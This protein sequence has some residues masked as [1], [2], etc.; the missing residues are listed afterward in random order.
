MY[1]EIV[2]LVIEIKKKVENRLGEGWRSEGRKEK[3]SLQ[4][5]VVKRSKERVSGGLNGGRGIGVA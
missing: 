5:L 1:E 4:E 2:E 3:V